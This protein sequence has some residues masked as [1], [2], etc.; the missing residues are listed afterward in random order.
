MS[1][2]VVV[3]DSAHFIVI[4]VMHMSLAVQCVIGDVGIMVIAKDMVLAHMRCPHQNLLCL[5][6]LYADGHWGGQLTI[7]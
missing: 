6:G 4:C 3:R 7:S 5:C 2:W 1:E